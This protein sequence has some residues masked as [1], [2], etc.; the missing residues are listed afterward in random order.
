MATPYLSV[1][2]PAYNEEAR[3]VGSLQ[4]IVAYLNTRAYTWEV[5]VA[6]DGSNDCTNRLVAEF[7][8][9]SPNIQLLDLVHKGKG[10]AAQ[11]GMLAAKGEYRCLCDADL[12]A[13]IGQVERLL[14]ALAGNVAIA[15]GSREVLGA[16]RIG[17]PARR[18]LMGRVY[19]W[20]VRRLAVPNL[21][22]TQCGFKCF[23]GD[24][25]DDLFNRQ[26]THGFAFDV[27]VLFLAGKAG[28]A[29]EEVPVDW[30]YQERSKV[31]VLRDP[32]RMTLDL[33]AIRWRYFR[34]LYHLI[35]D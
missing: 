12:S 1:V 13:P 8:A 11:Q 35:S 2:I 26:A 28:L 18:R 17:E 24:V 29:M 6:N 34:G 30:Y 20:L 22:D 10:W 16:R 32:F 14:K 4:R 21:K 3:I 23:R 5:V 33:L 31:R 7:S 27:E 9:N 15:I 19:N 25:A